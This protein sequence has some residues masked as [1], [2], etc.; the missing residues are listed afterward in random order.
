MGQPRIISL[1]W[2]HKL[3]WTFKINTA[4]RSFWLSLTYTYFRRHIIRTNY[5]KSST[6]SKANVTHHL[7]FTTKQVCSILN[8][9][10]SRVPLASVPTDLVCLRV[11]SGYQNVKQLNQTKLNTR[12]TKCM[13]PNIFNYKQIYIYMA[14]KKAMPHQHNPRALL[15]N[16]P[17]S[18]R[19]YKRYQYSYNSTFQEIASSEV[20]KL[21]ALDQNLVVTLPSNILA[22]NGVRPSVDAELTRN[23]ITIFVQFPWILTI[24][25]IYVNQTQYM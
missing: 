15:I 3:Q 25:D 22:S 12:W 18:L 21:Q 7:F 14:Y 10:I 19:W 11:N 20:L 4:R 6:F 13:K 24:I 17:Y 2:S 23:F 9:Q 16:L 8:N 1:N 5:W